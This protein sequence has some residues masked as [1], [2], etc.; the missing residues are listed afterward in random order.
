MAN[1]EG[2]PRSSSRKSVTAPSDASSGAGLVA[3]EGAVTDLRDEDLGL[4]SVL[5]MNYQLVPSGT[6]T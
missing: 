4:P 1:T 6:N 5:A 3:S 2:K